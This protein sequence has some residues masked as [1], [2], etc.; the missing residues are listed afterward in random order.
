MLAPK[1]AT[2]KEN[3]FNSTIHNQA[4]TFEQESDFFME[5][6]QN[7]GSNMEANQVHSTPAL[8]KSKREW[9]L[10]EKTVTRIGIRHDSAT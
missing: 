3:N 7:E 6:A 10:M 1:T 4:T 5:T 2:D 8:W 9:K